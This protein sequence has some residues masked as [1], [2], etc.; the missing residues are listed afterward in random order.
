MQHQVTLKKMP[1]LEI[2][3]SDLE[4]CV[5]TGGKKLGTLKISRGNLEWL[6]SN[7]SVRSHKRTWRE[8]ADLMQS[9]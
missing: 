4:L 9:Q 2:G 3:N 1:E 7:K 5:K 6:P 8:F